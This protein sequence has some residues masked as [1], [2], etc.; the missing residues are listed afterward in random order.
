LKS[1]RSADPLPRNVAEALALCRERLGR[2]GSSI[3]Y[4]STVPSTNDIAAERAAKG[5]EGAIVFADSQTAGRGRMGRSWFSPPGNG[6]YVSVVLVPAGSVDGERALTLVTLAA[7]VALAEGVEAATALAADIKWP[8]D[9]YVSRRKLAGVLAEAAPQPSADVPAT[10]VLG[11]GINV[12]ASAYPPALV[13]RATSLETELGRPVD[14]P[15]LFVET[16]AALARRYDDL[17]TGRFDAIL[18]AWRARSPQSRGARVSWTTPGGPRSGTTAG[19]DD[20]GALLVRVGGAVER[21]V[22]GELT[23]F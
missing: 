2:L 13:D 14:R 3:D 7:G 12:G 20:R 15:L 23:W 6:L 4:Y 1:S 18:D 5:D 17:L 19:I 10:V 11:Y 16:L 22:S 21:I 9:L 8:N